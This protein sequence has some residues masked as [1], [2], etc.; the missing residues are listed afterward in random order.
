MKGLDPVYRGLCPN[1]G[2]PIRAERLEKGL[3]CSSCY[4][5]EAPASVEEIAER[6]SERGRLR[7]Y[8]WLY[9]L[10]TRFRD[11]SAYFESRT[12]SSLWS[13]QRSWAR[14]LLALESLAIIAPTGV[15]KTTLLMAYAAYRV[16]RDGWR[17]LYLVPTENLARQVASRLEALLGERVAYYYSSLPRARREEMLARIEAR[18]YGVLVATTSFLQ[19]RFD[20]L[21]GTRFDLV[22]VDDVDS[23]LRNSRNVD[24]VL[25]LL[26]FPVEALEAAEKLVRTRLRLYTALAAGRRDLVEKY[27]AE[28]AE[29]E[30]SLHIHLPG[31]AGQLVIASATGRPRGLKHLLFKELLGFEV[32][33]GTDYMRD[34]TDSYP[35]SAGPLEKGAEVVRG[36]AESV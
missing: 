35:L 30:E 22:I 27:E 32:G 15:G 6:L 2:G 14:R 10:E 19:R 20:L 36:L 23:L 29:A 33:G 25:M 7:G 18:D 17:V 13:A 5:W 12:G 11:F 1:C 8:L 24:R 16:E 28:V 34:V 26:G 31:D 3:P 4:P 9:D 21:R